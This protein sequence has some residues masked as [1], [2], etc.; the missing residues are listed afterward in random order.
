MSFQSS[1]IHKYHINIHTKI[2]QKAPD[3]N[4]FEKPH[5]GQTGWST[6]SSGQQQIV[7]SPVPAWRPEIFTSHR[8][9]RSASGPS[10]LPPLSGERS[11]SLYPP[12]HPVCAQSIRSP[13]SARRPELFC[14]PPVHPVYRPDRPVCHRT[15]RC[16]LCTCSQSI[17][18]RGS[19]CRPDHPVCTG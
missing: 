6:G 4:S 16:A 19:R 1:S 12:D 9:I 15:I 18:C 14:G 3:R 11:Y 5:L 8:M 2:P 7:R 17:R 13:A 10:G